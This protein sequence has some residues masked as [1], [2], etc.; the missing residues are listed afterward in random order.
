MAGFQKLN[1]PLPRVGCANILS[2]HSLDSVGRASLTKM[3]YHIY[4]TGQRFGKWTL[5]GFAKNSKGRPRRIATCDCGNVRVVAI[6]QLTSGVSRSCGCI[7]PEITRATHYKHGSTNN[8]EYSVWKNMKE[9]CSNPNNKKF[10]N[11]GGRGISVCGKWEN[12]FAAFLKDMGK[13]PSMIHSIDRINSNGNY[14]PSNCRWALKLEQANNRFGNRIIEHGGK[15]Q[16]L[17][18]WCRELSLPYQTIHA[19][20]TDLNWDFQTAIIK[21]IQHHAKK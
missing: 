15:T 10:F 1:L 20:I 12:D 6:S 11:Y 14:E 17:A 18:M 5:G 2:N 16:T 21:P 13:R 3:K 4:K 8:P 19:R 9:R 7:I